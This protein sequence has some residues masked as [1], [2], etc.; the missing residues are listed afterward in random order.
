MVDAAAGRERESLRGR[1]NREER[2]REEPSEIIMIR[3]SHALMLSR[4]A[5]IRDGCAFTTA[6]FTALFFFRAHAFFFPVF[7][8]CCSYDSMR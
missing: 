3:D 2:K 1:D 7:P 6:L 8:V 4:T 5:R